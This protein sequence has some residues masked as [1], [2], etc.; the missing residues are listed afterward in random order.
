MEDKDPNSDS[1]V[2]QVGIVI[3]TDP[4]TG[5]IKVLP[6]T[7]NPS[8]YQ[9]KSELLIKGN[10][11]IVSQ[12]KSVKSG[13]LLD[14]EGLTPELSQSLKNELIYV[15]SSQIPTNKE[16][17]Y[18]HFQLIGLKV[19]DEDT[20]LLGNITEILQTGANDVYIVQSEDA[21]ILIPAIASAVLSVNLS[22]QEMIVKIPEGLEPR[23]LK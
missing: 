16:G 17:S 15:P 5:W 10:V 1:E 9:K 21:E 11:Y 18:Y 7:D 23:A 13:F 4:S 8:R 14:L 3:A 20:N 22:A 6:Q 2:V 12:S 19:I